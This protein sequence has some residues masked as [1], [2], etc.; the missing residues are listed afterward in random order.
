MG[1]G[2]TIAPELEANPE[3]FDCEVLVEQDTRNNAFKAEHQILQWLDAAGDEN[4]Y[5]NT[6]E[7][8]PREGLFKRM[9]GSRKGPLSDQEVESLVEKIKENDSVQQGESHPSYQDNLRKHIED[10]AEI[11]FQ[12]GFDFGM[13]YGLPFRKE[14]TLSIKQETLVILLKKEIFL[15]EKE[16]HKINV[17]IE[18]SSPIGLTIYTKL[19]A[20]KDDIEYIQTRLEEV[21]EKKGWFLLYESKFEEGLQA[22]I[23]VYINN[24]SD[25][26]NQRL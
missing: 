21:E 12:K 10:G 24:K 11:F 17:I 7:A 13:R 25:L 16:T 20:I 3:D 26:L 1:S 6:N 22:G 19:E 23:L 8:W 2:I 14:E 4:S 18:K 5:N 15:R 9:F